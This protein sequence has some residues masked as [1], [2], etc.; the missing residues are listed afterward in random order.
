MLDLESDEEEDTVS[1]YK[2]AIE[3]GVVNGACVAPAP[4]LGGTT[5]VGPKGVMNIS[6][7]GIARGGLL[8][9]P[10]PK[11]TLPDNTA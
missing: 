10:D 7:F 1:F 11:P 2:I 9:R 6:I 8:S 3:A 4:H 5:R